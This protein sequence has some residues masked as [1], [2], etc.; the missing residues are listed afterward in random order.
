MDPERT[1]KRM[2]VSAAEIMPQ[3]QHDKANLLGAYCM[4]SFPS[5]RRSTARNRCLGTSMC[6]QGLSKGKRCSF[7]ERCPQTTTSEF[8]T[9]GSALQKVLTVFLKSA[10]V[11]GSKAS[12]EWQSSLGGQR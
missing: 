12:Q 1:A 2:V 8:P 9:K 5:V 4:V 7:V 3:A 6:F 11:W 10:H